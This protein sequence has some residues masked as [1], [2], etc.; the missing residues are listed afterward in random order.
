MVAGNYLASTVVMGLLAA[1]VLYAT[2]N[3]RSWKRYSPQAVSTEGNQGGFVTGGR[4]WIVAFG[5]LSIAAVGGTLTIL[6]SGGNGTV[7]IFG[8][9]AALVV[10]FLLLG[11]YA[12]A[13]SRGH[14]HSHAIGETVGMAGAVVILAIVG[15]LLIR[16]GA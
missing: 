7:L 5:L 1:S 10:G 12:T 11:T 16:F 14:P 6:Q 3:G 2:V 13:R 4:T 15:N 9:A 8:A